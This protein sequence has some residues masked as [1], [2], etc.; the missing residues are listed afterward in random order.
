MDRETEYTDGSRDAPGFVAAICVRDHWDEMSV[1]ER[2]WCAEVVRAEILR[3]SEQWSHFERMQRFSMMADCP[4]A[5]VVSLGA[6]IQAEP[7]K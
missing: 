2:D 3:K 4:C 7:C 6:Y 1:D 5:S